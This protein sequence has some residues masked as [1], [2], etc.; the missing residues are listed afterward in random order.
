LRNPNAIPR[1]GSAIELG[2]NILFVV[3]C[4]TYMHTSAVSIGSA[5]RFT[6]ASAWVWFFWS[7]LALGLLNALAASVKLM[8]PWWTT[9]RASIQLATSAAGAVLFCLLLRANIL[10]SLTI[11]SLP[12]EKSYDLAAAVNHWAALMF[13][14]GV[15][16][17]L[18]VAAS[19][20]YRIIRVKSA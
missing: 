15:L 5:V 13:P 7:Y 1:A 18:A 10:T 9:T 3:W 12:P 14:V 6:L 11:S 19:D 17:G 16:I 2:I 8:R 4:A 20:I